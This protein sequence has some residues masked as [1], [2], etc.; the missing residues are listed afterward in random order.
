MVKTIG[1]C[2]DLA[3]QKLGDE[4]GELFTDA[5]LRPHIISAFRDLGRLIKN[6]QIPRA[7]RIRYAQILANQSSFTFDWSPQ[8]SGPALPDF[9]SQIAIEERAETSSYSISTI[10]GTGSDSITITT[11]VAH[12][13]TVGNMVA[14]IG[15]GW[16]WLDGMHAVYSIPSS[17]S[18]TVRGTYA[19]G[20]TNV[21]VVSIGQ[22]RF[23][24]VSIEPWIRDY[25]QTLVNQLESVAVAEN[26]LLFAPCN[27][28]RQVRIVYNADADNLASDSDL[29]GWDDAIDFLAVV[30]GQYAASSKGAQG[31]A[32]MLEVLAF[33][34]SRNR[35]NPDGGLARALLA[36]A[37]RSEQ[38]Q[39]WAR[40][41]WRQ[42]RY[43]L[44]TP[45]PFV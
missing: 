2:I 15:T 12:G 5:I 17:S 11:S 24:P 31:K 20:T 1:D 7:K 23:Q 36:D 39:Q 42:R 29:I 45:Y 8:A 30:G 41:T 13:L 34:P 26:T 6:V 44:G 16:R 37:V 14:L 10:S 22:D 4:S 3:Q 38:Q 19:A 33:G 9:A 27:N 32:D 21:G 25:P 18:F 28:N 35:T 43:P 40:P